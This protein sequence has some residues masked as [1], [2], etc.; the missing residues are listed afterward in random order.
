MSQ[1]LLFHSH[2]MTSEL[3]LPCEEGWRCFAA[4]GVLPWKVWLPVPSDSEAAGSWEDVLS[5]TALQRSPV[6]KSQL[7]LS[8][9]VVAP[10]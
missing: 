4:K 1:D 2:P 8:E 6:P 9:S 3:L 5:N 7:L 10:F